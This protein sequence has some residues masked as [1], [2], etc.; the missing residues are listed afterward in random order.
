M[1]LAFAAVGLALLSCG[2]APLLAAAPRYTASSIVNA[3][4]GVSSI[5]APNGLATIYGTDLAGHTQSLTASDLRGDQLPYT[6]NG[7]GVG[8]IVSGLRAHVVFVSPSQVNFLVPALLPPGTATVVLTRLGVSGDHVKVLIAG[9][10]PGLFL[11]K[12]GLAV[13]ARADGSVITETAP[14]LPGEVAVLYATGLGQTAPPLGLGERARK[15]AW[16][17]RR[18]EFAV[19]LDGRT[20]TAEVL[21]AGVT[22]GFGGL[23][24]VNLRLPEHTGPNPEIRLLCGDTASPAGVRLAVGTLTGRDASTQ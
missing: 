6:L 5:L 9:C 17:D 7:T 23:Y 19:V 2:A 3:A 18:E 13:A 10:S 4:S 11:L 22:P 15:A 14:A 16:I 20:L 1:R 21:Y 8:V 24:Q 12:P